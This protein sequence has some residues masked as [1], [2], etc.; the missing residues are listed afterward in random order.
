MRV[1]GKAIGMVE[2]LVVVLDKATVEGRKSLAQGRP[3]LEQGVDVASIWH[4]PAVA[5]IMARSS[6][7]V[8][9]WSYVPWG[10]LRSSWQP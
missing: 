9:G 1:A 6:W 5:L 4:L 3:S 10:G 8:V 2:H 7:W